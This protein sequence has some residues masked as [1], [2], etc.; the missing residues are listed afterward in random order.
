M[1]EVPNEVD[2]EDEDG[3][4]DQDLPELTDPSTIPPDEG[5]AGK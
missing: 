5:D 3:L 1:T 2:E 4:E